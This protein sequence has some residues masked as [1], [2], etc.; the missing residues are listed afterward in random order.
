MWID[1]FD[2]EVCDECEN[3]KHYWRNNDM[4]EEC[5]GKIVGHALNIVK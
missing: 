5:Q 2:K 1:P 3:C 4:I